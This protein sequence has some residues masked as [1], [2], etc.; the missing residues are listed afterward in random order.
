MCP[1]TLELNMSD[2]SNPTGKDTQ[3]ALHSAAP[4]L[5]PQDQ[6]QLSETLELLATIAASLSDRVDNQGKKLD[7]L[8]RTA[9]ETRT[10]AFAAQ[11]ATD[12]KVPVEMIKTALAE[13]KV[14]LTEITSALVNAG[15]KIVEGSGRNKKL[16]EELNLKHLGHLNDE[17]NGIVA[18]RKKLKKTYRTRALFFA[19]FCLISA[20]LL[21]GQMSKYET[22]CGLLG[23]KWIT[24][25]DGQLGCWWKN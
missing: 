13:E 3:S 18:D 7:K 10:S 1:K 14:A 8:E 5:S 9:A 15:T 4:A 12:P 20:V 6:S 2:Q 19:L 11:K 23:A 21:P 24:T 16:I 22:G 25:T 17:K